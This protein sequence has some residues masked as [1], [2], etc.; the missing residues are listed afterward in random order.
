MVPKGVVDRKGF[1]TNRSERTIMIVR[2]KKTTKTKVQ[3][4]E[5]RREEEG[6]KQEISS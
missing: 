6:G 2:M 4:D 1:G 5:C 3:D